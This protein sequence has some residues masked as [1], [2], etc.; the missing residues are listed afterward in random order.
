M[1]C[2]PCLQVH[3]NFVWLQVLFMNACIFI[4]MLL[5]NLLPAPAQE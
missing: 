1:V 3:V 4:A 5:D 2:W